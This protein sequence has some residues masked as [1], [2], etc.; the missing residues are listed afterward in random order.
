MATVEVVIVSFAPLIRF[1]LGKLR[2]GLEVE[3]VPFVA[4]TLGAVVVVSVLVLLFRTGLLLLLASSRLLIAAL[5]SR[6]SS[7][8]SSRAD[9]SFLN[10]GQ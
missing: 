9:F 8:S 5:F 1:G 3:V 4:V 10:P 6:S 7:S 2:A